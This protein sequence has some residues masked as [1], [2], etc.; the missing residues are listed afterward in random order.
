MSEEKE[1]VASGTVTTQK[2]GFRLYCLSIIG[3][4]E[5]HSTLEAGIKTTKYEH[6][7]PDLVAVEENASVDGMLVLLNTV[8]GD[9]EAGLAMAELV[10]SMKKP[11][12]SL[13]LG[14]SHSIGV[15]LAVAAGYSFIAPSAA[16]TIHPVRL[17]GLVIAVAQTFS[18]FERMQERI[19]RFVTDNSHIRREDF[20][21]LMLQTGELTADV[22]SVVYGEQAVELGLI[23]RVGGLS[24][25]L[26]KLFE[27]IREKKEAEKEG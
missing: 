4:V 14:G 22:G 10:A 12:V 11:T 26:E 17:N 5:G 6:V 15:P 16:M 25:A 2:D 24:D 27:M 18:Y 3:Q 23:D 8:G 1:I 7:L 20:T 13:V 21:S 19:I 9:V